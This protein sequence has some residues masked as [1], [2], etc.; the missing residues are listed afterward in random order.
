MKWFKS[1]TFADNTHKPE[2]GILLDC[3]RSQVWRI[4]EEMTSTYT[5]RKH[6]RGMVIHMLEGLI[7]CTKGAMIHKV[8]TRRCGHEGGTKG[9]HQQVWMHVQVVQ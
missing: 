3:S 2:G 9:A 5:T 1:V 8:V 7:T 4:Q 6:T